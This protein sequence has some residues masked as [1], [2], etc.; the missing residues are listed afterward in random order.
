MLRAKVTVRLA[1]Q[2]L[3][4]SEFLF[5]R[6]AR[7]QRVYLLLDISLRRR[8]RDRRRLER[9]RC[10]EQNG[11]SDDER[12]VPCRGWWLVYI[13]IWS[14]TGKQRDA[15]MNGREKKPVHSRRG[16]THT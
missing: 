12:K 11:Q 2:L 10:G 3:K 16:S 8:G 14:G 9:R 15:R 5:E 13:H 7:E 4:L 6:H 1:V